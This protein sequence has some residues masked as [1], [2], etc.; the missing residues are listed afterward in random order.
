MA[1]LSSSG[2]ID[3]WAPSSRVSARKAAWGVLNERKPT[4]LENPSSCLAT[5]HPWNTSSRPALVTNRR[6]SSSSAHSGRRQTNRFAPRGPSSRETADVS[7]VSL[8][9]SS[10]ERPRRTPPGPVSLVP[11]RSGP[12]IA[13]PPCGV[14]WGSCCCI[15]TAAAE[16]G[17]LGKLVPGPG[18]PPHSGT[19]GPVE[20]GGRAGKEG[21]GNVPGAGGSCA[22]AVSS[23]P[24]CCCRRLASSRS[25]SC[26]CCCSRAARAGWWR[27]WYG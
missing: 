8:T 5:E 3:S 22:A 21:R 25:S 1:I 11:A 16:I 7:L 19:E 6:R 26:L 4:F 14:M 17:K 18:P 15:G 20:V 27:W 12:V 24:C 13:P 23:S 2:S 9:R 10:P